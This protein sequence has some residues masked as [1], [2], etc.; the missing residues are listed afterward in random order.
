MN[1]TEK[2]HPTVGAVEQ[3][4]AGNVLA[5]SYSRNHCT[6]NPVA[7]QLKI[8]DLLSTGQENALPLSYL[9]MTTGQD[10]RTIRRMIAEERFAGVPILADN[11]SGYYLPANEDER[12]RCVRSMRHRA[13]EIDRA[14]QAIEAA[15]ICQDYML[16]KTAQRVPES[17]IGQMRMEVV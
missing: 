7:G 4:Q 12:R 1:K 10:G 16:R 5:D 15:D 9:M 11:Q 14:A 2:A 8:S 13:K 17:T 3:A 6:S